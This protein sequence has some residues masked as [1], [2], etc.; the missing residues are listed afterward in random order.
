MHGA[1]EMRR[2]ILR[3][4]ARVLRLDRAGQGNGGEGE[5]VRNPCACQVHEPKETVRI[6]QDRVTLVEHRRRTFQV[7]KARRDLARRAEP[8]PG[9]F[10][11]KES[12]EF[13][14]SSLWDIY[15]KLHT[16]RGRNRQ[17]ELNV[18]IPVY[19]YGPQHAAAC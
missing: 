12:A 18:R 5:A 2:V 19:G 14:L 3:S 10:P 1:S 9:R 4:I 7:R 13:D 6:R 15:Y 11:P 17:L 8:A 16:V